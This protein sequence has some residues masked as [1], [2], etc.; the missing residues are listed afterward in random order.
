MGSLEQLVLSRSWLGL[1]QQ[2]WWWQQVPGRR[3]PLVPVGIP[4][5]RILH[6]SRTDD[7]HVQLVNFQE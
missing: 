5:G 2:R 6:L 3:V 4:H 7:Q 1:E